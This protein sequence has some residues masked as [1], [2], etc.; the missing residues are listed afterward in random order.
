MTLKHILAALALG[1]AATGAHAGILTFDALTDFMVGDGTPL[2]PD[3]RYDGSNLVYLEGGMQLTLNA[4]GAIPGEAHLGDGT[5]TPQTFNWHDGLENGA[6]TW[7]TLARADGGKFDL[8]GFDYLTDMSTVLADGVAVGTI[9]DA[10][11]WT[12]RL[13]GITELRW[14]AGS[15]NQIDNVDV[16]AAAAAVPLPGTLA[17]LLGGAIAGRLARRRKR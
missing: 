17:L 14:N 7:L 10:G 4:P 15:Y 11:S 12:T 9:A 13:A 3:M 5:F 6:G 2:V 1:C 8:R 16:D